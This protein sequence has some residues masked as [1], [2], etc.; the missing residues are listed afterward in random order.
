MKKNLLHFALP[1]VCA[2]VLLFAFTNKPAEDRYDYMLIEYDAY[3]YELNIST[4]SG[5]FSTRVVKTLLLD[6]DK[7]RTPLLTE[8]KTQE[9]NGWE[10]SSFASAARSNAQVY[11]CFMRKKL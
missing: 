5:T 2:L 3:S 11:T 1:A 4:T 9:A 7:D 8:V 10:T 6:K